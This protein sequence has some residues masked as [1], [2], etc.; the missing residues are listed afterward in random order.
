MNPCSQHPSVQA[1]WECT[2][3][4]RLLCTQCAAADT[5]NNAPIVRCRICGNVVQEI[6]QPPAFT[7]GYE[8]PAERVELSSGP[9]ATPATEEPIANEYIPQE[10][11]LPSAP[12]AP[13]EPAAAASSPLPDPDESIAG[14]LDDS[15]MAAAM[16]DPGRRTSAE[17]AAIPAA[18]LNPYQQ[19]ESPPL[20]GEPPPDPMEPLRSALERSDE[21]GAIDA[22]YRLTGD[23]QTPDLE[24]PMELRLTQFLGNAN[25]YPD[26]VNSCRRAVAKQPDGP[27][28]PAAIFTAARLMG[29]KLGQHEQAQAALQYLLQNYPQ[30]PL[31]NHARQMLGQR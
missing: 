27:M 30:S 12:T 4:Q 26:A 10:V 2:A 18:G 6:V 17:I 16:Y 24:V 5:Y 19:A 23:G 22:Y 9:L 28:A 14:E 13:S 3:C 8:P 7:R 21:A 20:F 25:L 1:G 31:C 11:V 15:S 29:E